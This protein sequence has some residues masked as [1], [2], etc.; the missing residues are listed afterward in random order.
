MLT[1]YVRSS[2]K[3]YIS[4]RYTGGNP[5]LFVYVLDPEIEDAI[6]G[7]IRRTSSGTYIALDPAITQDILAAFR[8]EIGNLPPT[9]QQPVIVTDQEIRRFVRRIA[10]L[11]FRNLAVL[12]YQEL[13]P[14]L[15]I[16]P[17]ARISLQAGR[18]QL[19]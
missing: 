17:L 14:E 10:E 16:Q 3:R 9:A 11:E 13:A 18:G 7:A 5:I 15:S 12:S 2:L 4:F 1:E 8:R 6:R 19:R